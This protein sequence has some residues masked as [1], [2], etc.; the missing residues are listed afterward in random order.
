MSE[1][2]HIV[3]PT[4]KDQTGH[5]YSFVD[6]FC[7][8]SN[9]VSIR[10]WANKNVDIVFGNE[11]VQVN[12][13]FHTKLRRLQ[14][15]GLY[16]KLLKKPGRIFIST[17]SFFDLALIK[18]AARGTIHANKVYC[19]FHWLN[20]S[21]KKRVFLAKLASKQ[22]NLVMLGPTPSVVDLFKEAGFAHASVVPYP[23][24]K[25]INKTRTGH[26]QFNGLLYAGAA[27]QD[28]GITHVVNLVEH[29]S[30][31]KLQIP[32]RLQNSPDHRGKYDDATKADIDRLQGVAYPHL[33]LYPKTLSHE[34]YANLFNGAIC[35]QLYNATDF[36]DRISGVTL[37]ALSAGSPIITT[38]G[39]WIANMVQRFDAGRVVERTEPDEILSA[40]QE[41]IAD[42]STYNENAYQAG[43]TLQQENSA[44]ILFNIVAA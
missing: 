22:P 2:I 30:K 12:K 27:R 42:Y 39:S 36:S 24:S 44:A 6:S 9:G 7:Q 20:I 11:N 8:A 35:V 28:K 13:H 34:E 38:A 16:R 26:D 21:D 29:M 40:I 25:Q 10:L 23:I 37:D 33:R 1:I 32:V 4:L 5:C 18:W 15:F 3:E 43:L 41:I 31:L 17:A 19:Y 14:S